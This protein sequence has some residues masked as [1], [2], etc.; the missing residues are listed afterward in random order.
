MRICCALVDVETIS[1]ALSS[2]ESDCNMASGSN[3]KHD[4]AGTVFTFSPELPPHPL[5]LEL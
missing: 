5:L 4:A 3:I 2:L 1:F